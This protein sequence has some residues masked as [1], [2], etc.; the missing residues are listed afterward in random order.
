MNRWID[1]FRNRKGLALVGLTVIVIGGIF[2]VTNTWGLSPQVVEPVWRGMLFYQTLHDFFHKIGVGSISLMLVYFWATC[3]LG[4]RVGII[5][6]PALTAR[7]DTFI[8]LLVGFCPD[9]RS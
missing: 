5:F 2:L 8:L 9:M 7:Q 1:F 6:F 3:Y 4:Y